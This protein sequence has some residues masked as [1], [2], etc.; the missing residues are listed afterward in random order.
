MIERGFRYRKGIKASRA[1]LQC[2]QTKSEE[3]YTYFGTDGNGKVIANSLNADLTKFNIALVLD[4]CLDAMISANIL[5]RLVELQSI[6][7][8]SVPT[9]VHFAASGHLS[10]ERH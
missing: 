6:L 9:C 3:R 7:D 4:S 5:M 10:V 2:I 1:R 8:S